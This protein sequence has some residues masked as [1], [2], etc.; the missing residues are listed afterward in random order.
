M[1]VKI[2]MTW[3]KGNFVDNPCV[4][5]EQPIHFLDMPRVICYKR[6]L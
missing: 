1:S 2:A 3:P 4:H 6:S 5:S